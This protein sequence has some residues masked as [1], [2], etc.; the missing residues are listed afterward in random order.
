M[1]LLLYNSKFDYNFLYD[2][3]EKG[4]MIIAFSKWVSSSFFLYIWNCYFFIHLNLEYEK[5]AFFLWLWTKGYLFWT[6]GRNS[7]ICTNRCVKF[8]QLKSNPLGWQYFLTYRIVLV[9][10]PLVGWWF[11]GDSFYH[12]FQL[13]N[14]CVVFGVQKEC[15]LF[16]T[17]HQK[18]IHDFRFFCFVFNGEFSEG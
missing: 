4:V 2:Y 6:T 8:K 17:N 16:A 10:E 18:N 15:W 13:Q 1:L 11:F 9:K 7:Y 14:R 12:S 3:V 5:I